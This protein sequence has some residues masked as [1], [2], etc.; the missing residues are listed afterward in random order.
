MTEILC[1]EGFGVE[2]QTSNRIHY[3]N[4]DKVTISSAISSVIEHY[5]P[6]NENKIAL[7]VLRPKYT[8]QTN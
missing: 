2:V 6:W 8:L 1:I 3:Q 5:K 7:I 4:I